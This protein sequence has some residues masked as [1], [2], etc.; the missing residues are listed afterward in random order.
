MLFQNSD[1]SAVINHVI[2]TKV[3][4]PFKCQALIW[5][6]FVRKPL[7]SFFSIEIRIYIDGVNNQESSRVSWDVLCVR[8]KK[9]VSV[10]STYGSRI[11]L[12][13]VISNVIY[14]VGEFFVFFLHKI[15]IWL[16][17]QRGWEKERERESLCILKHF[18]C[19]FCKFG[20]I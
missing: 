15:S 9:R 19:R 10:R 1:W 17:E 5:I 11:K 2:E 14:I 16:A 8:A 6:S 4:H 7:H 20:W 12:I 13:V 18:H 3:P